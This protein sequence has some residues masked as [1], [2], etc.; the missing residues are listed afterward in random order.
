MRYELIDTN[1]LILAT[2]VQYKIFPN[3]IAYA[4]YKESIEDNH[5]HFKYYLVYKENV[6]IGITGLYANNNFEDNSI[7]LGWYGVIDEYRL[8]GFGKQIL[9][10]TFNMAKE[11]AEKEPR[12]KYLR[13]YTSSRDNKIAQIL[14][15]KYMDI[16]EEYNNPNDINFDNTCLVYTKVIRKGDN[17][18]M[19]NN[20]FLN[21]KNGDELIN[22]GLHEFIRLT[23]GDINIQ[24]SSTGEIF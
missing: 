17:N 12:I 21:L 6:I 24:I 22:N 9:F 2:R 10:D 11:W 8:H 1:N 18:K 19:W 7:W 23:N 5:R 20:R 16:C 4:C 14:Y 15:K 3:E 13:L